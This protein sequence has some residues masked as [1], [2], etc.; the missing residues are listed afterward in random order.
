V[1]PRWLNAVV[2]RAVDVLL[3]LPVL[4]IALMLI[5]TAG[6]GVRSI[7]LA[8]GIASPRGFARIVEG[9]VRTLRSAEFVQAAYVF[10]STRLR[11]SLRHLLPNLVTEVVVLAAARSAGRC[12]PRPR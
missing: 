8:I 1:A 4:L 7:V 5:A 12:S 2:M 11:T 10:G 9:S 3:A 6:S